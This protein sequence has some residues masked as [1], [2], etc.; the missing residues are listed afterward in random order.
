MQRGKDY[1]ATPFEVLL[2]LTQ[3]SQG[4][5]KTQSTCISPF[6]GII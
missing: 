2:I 3:G 5:I 1:F 6:H 4:E